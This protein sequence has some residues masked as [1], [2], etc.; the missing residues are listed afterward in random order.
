ME[1]RKTTLNIF[2]GFFSDFFWIFFGF[3][4]QKK[5]KKIFD[6]KLCLDYRNNAMERRKTSFNIFFGFFSDFLSK[7]IKKYI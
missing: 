1:R 4:W 7:K 2:F 6:L 5:L 3:F